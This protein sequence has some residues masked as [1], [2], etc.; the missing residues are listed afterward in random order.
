M[1]VVQGRAPP[2][3]RL[4]PPRRRGTRQRLRVPARTHPPRSTSTRQTFTLERLAGNDRKTTGSYYTPPALVSALLDTA[5]DPVL[6]EAVKSAKDPADAEAAPARRHRLRPRLRLRRVPRR[7]RPADRPP[8]WPS[9]LRRGRTH[10]GSRSQH[11]LHDVVGR[12]IYG[13][14]LNDLAAE[15][16]KVSASG[17]RPSSPASRSGSSTPA[18]ESATPCSA[19]PPRC[20]PRA[21]PT[22]RSRRS[23]ATTRSTPRPCASRTRPSAQGSPALFDRRRAGHRH[24]RPPAASHPDPRPRRRHHRRTAPSAAAWAAYEHSEQLRRARLHADAWCA[25]FVWPLQRRAPPAHPPTT[26]SPRSPRT[27]T[28]LALAPTVAEVDRLADEYR[29]FHWHLE[30]PEVFGDP[31]AA[32]RRTGR[33]A[34]RLHLPARQPPVGARQAPGAGV[35]RLPRTRASPTPPEPSA[36]T[37]HR[38]TYP[39]R[40]RRCAQAYARD[41]RHIDGMQALRRR[42]GPLPTER[43]RPSQHLLGVRRTVPRH[44]PIPPAGPG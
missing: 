44:S 8:R 28:T 11:A 27:P 31:G 5:L 4:P 23:P 32:G 10:P 34:R 7:S 35:L 13:V 20:W 1:G 3:R 14:D 9:P 15:L 17:W 41:K 29:F 38:D 22:T 19:P 24:H 39:R 16:A 26:C 18:S 12:C 2:T 25:A 21:C 30:F 42:L 36:K 40:S 33:L 43:P 37:T 6:D